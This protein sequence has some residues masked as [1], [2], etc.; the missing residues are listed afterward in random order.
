[1]ACKLLEL[2]EFLSEDRALLTPG[3][4]ILIYFLR[5]HLLRRI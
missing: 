5:L 4:S 2:Q 3:L 1:M